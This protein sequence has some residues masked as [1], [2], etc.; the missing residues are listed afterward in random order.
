M[1]DCGS[2]STDLSIPRCKICNNGIC[3]CAQKNLT[4]LQ[5]INCSLFESTECQ[6]QKFEGSKLFY[7]FFI[8]KLKY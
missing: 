6:T 2:S 8:N 1:T 5:N 4:N 7:I 3:N